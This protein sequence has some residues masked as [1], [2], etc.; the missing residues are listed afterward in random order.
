M[1]FRSW[2]SLRNNLPASSVRDVIV[3]GDDLAI[4]THGRGFWV[5]DDITPLRQLTPQTLDEAAFLFKPQVAHRV[6]WDQNTDTP[7][8]PDTP[9]AENPPDGAVIN[10]YLGPNASGPVTLQIKD[11][12]GIVREYSSSDPVPPPDPKLRDRKSTRLNSSHI[13]KS[14]MPSSA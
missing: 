2:Q 5:L 11:S 4:G 14:R 12:K 10:Y 7:L 9:A 8:P 1:L 13:Q 3:K 6:R